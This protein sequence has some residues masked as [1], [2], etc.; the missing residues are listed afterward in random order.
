MTS[1]EVR[2]VL[3]AVAGYWPTPA[4]TT[5]EVVAWTTELCGPSRITY[6]EALATV[7]A[8][9]GREWRP[10]AGQIVAMVQHYRRQESLRRPK[11]ALPPGGY[12]TPEAN[13]AHVQRCRNLLTGSKAVST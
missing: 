12:C 7:K 6:D 1:D 10:R 5:E 8:E 13:V 9:A 2:T 11:P 3:A 4:L